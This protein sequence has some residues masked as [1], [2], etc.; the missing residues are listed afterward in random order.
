[1][2][3]GREGDHGIPGHGSSRAADGAKTGDILRN[4]AG[5]FATVEAES[6]TAAVLDY[7]HPLAGKSLVVKV[8]ILDVGKLRE[9][10]SKNSGAP[11]GRRD[12]LAEESGI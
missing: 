11:C 4:E 10:A 3:A 9:P 12:C 8:T 5:T 7:N 2:R 6:E 1:M